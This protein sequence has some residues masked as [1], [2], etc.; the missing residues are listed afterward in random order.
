MDRPKG[1]TATRSDAAVP[2][3]REDA[4]RIAAALQAARTPEPLGVDLWSQS[5]DSAARL[6]ELVIEEC[7]DAGA[8]LARVKVDPR[9][10]VAMGRPL[11]GQRWSYRIC[12]L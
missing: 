3:R 10:A 1:R 9:V 2:D 4:L 11:A 5:P 7:G 6:I 12:V 8:P